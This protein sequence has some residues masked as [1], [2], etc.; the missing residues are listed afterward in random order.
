MDSLPSG[1]R[2]TSGMKETNLGVYQNGFP[3]GYKFNGN[4]YIYNHH[5]IIVKIHEKANDQ[6]YI[7]GFLVQPF[8]LAHSDELLCNY[9]AFDEFL[10]KSRNFKEEFVKLDNEKTL[11]IE[12]AEHF[13]LPQILQSAVNFTYSVA[14]EPSSVK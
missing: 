3:L 6:S 11:L 13:F 7:V 14:F 2:I 9:W 5:H 4:F 12:Q 10:R 8:S 1:L